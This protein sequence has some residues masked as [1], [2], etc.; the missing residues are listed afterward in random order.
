VDAPAGVGTLVAGLLQACDGV[1]VPVQSRALAVRSLPAVLQTVRAA[2]GSHPLALDGV[3]VTMHRADDPV[4]AKILADL[5]GRLP[6]G[7]LLETAI[8]QDERLE[9]ASLR[10]VPAALLP[11]AGAAARAYLD[12]AME[13]RLRLDRARAGGGDDGRLAGLF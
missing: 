2:A 3:V 1:L 5:R 4:Q 7:T 10:C 9:E 13:L 12:L 11:S 8:L 6:P